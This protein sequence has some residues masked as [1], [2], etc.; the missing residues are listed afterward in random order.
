M[1]LNIERFGKILISRPAGKEA[2]LSA[3]AYIL[4][5]ELDGIDLDFLNVNVLTPSWLDNFIIGL[6]Q[7][8][9]GIK[10]NYLNKANASVEES[11]KIL[12]QS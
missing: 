4:P 7:D 2:Y 1:R 3:K 10:I 9:P 11:I 6:R 5:D 8:Y 12:A